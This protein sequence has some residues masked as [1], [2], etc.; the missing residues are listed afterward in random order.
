MGLSRAPVTRDATVTHT[1]Y[2]GPDSETPL[3]AT[4]DVTVT[5]VGPDGEEIDGSPFDATS[6]G[7]DTGRYTV[8]IPGQ[9]DVTMLTLTWSATLAGDDVTEVDQLEVCG[10]PLFSLA[11]ARAADTSL[12][13]TTTYPTARLVEVRLDVELEVEHITDRAWTR[14]YARVTQSGSGT[15][16]LLLAHPDDDRSARDVRTIRSATVDGTA[17]EDA[18]VAALVVRPDGSLRRTD[19][20]VWA[21]GSGNVV[22]EYEYGRDG[23]SETLVRAMLERLRYL[24]Q[25]PSSGIPDRAESFTDASGAQ[26]RLGA[27]GPYTTGMPEV[28]AVYA[29]H[30]ARPTADEPGTVG[31]GRSAPAA[32][33]LTYLP[34]RY[35]LFHG[36]G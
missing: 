8:T 29:R 34:Q 12:A 25:R 21:E 7:E 13:S 15:P 9:A 3:D 16:D 24:A 36:H 10:G 32:R 11:R 22:I 33:T 1:F 4:G 6:A 35:S 27:P 30:S 23:P 19:G 2:T 14:R 18:A 26:Y 31:T 28:D 5:V 20:G 17:L